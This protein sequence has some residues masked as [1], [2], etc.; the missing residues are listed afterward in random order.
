MT[1]H[2]LHP[3]EVRIKTQERVLSI[4]ESKRRIAEAWTPV[5]RLGIEQKEQW[6]RHLKEMEEAHAAI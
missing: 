1:K 5:T 2:H 6:L 3:E 4:Y